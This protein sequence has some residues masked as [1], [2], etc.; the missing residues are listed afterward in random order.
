MKLWQLVSLG[1]LIPLLGQSGQQGLT[2]AEKNK[3]LSRKKWYGT[4]SFSVNGSGAGNGPNS[5]WS[6]NNSSTL[7]L[8]INEPIPGQWPPST[9]ADP[10]FVTQT[11][12][13]ITWMTM[14]T[15]AA[16]AALDRGETDPAKLP[17]HFY[18]IQRETKEQSEFRS[19]NQ[20]RKDSWTG[21][22][23]SFA[24]GPCMLAAD[25]KDGTYDVVFQVGPTDHGSAIKHEWSSD[26]GSGTDDAIP[27]QHMAWF[28]Q[29]FYSQLAKRKLSQDM[30]PD[31]SIGFN[32]TG[33]IKINGP[34]GIIE[35]TLVA[36]FRFSPTPPSN[37]KLIIEP[38]D[39]AEYQKWRPEPGD[40]EDESGSILEIK[41]RVEEP[42]V[43]RDRRAKPTRVTFRLG[44]VSRYPGVCMNWPAIPGSAPSSN[45]RGP[46][47]DLQFPATDDFYRSDYTV[48][49][50]KQVAIISGNSAGDGGGEIEVDCF[51]GAAIGEIVAEAELADGRII[52]GEVKGQPGSRKILIPDREEGVSDIAKVWRTRR[53]SGLK[54]E[55]DDEQIPAGDS[56]QGPGDG[57]SV[58]EEYRGFFQGGAWRDNC[59]PNRKDLFID[60]RIGARAQSGI[61]LFEQITSLAVHDKI[62]KD[63]HPLDL[64]INFRSR[65]DRHVVDQH[66]LLLKEVSGNVGNAT[67]MPG[68]AFPGPP[69]NTLSVR[70]VLG[71]PGDVIYQITP[72]VRY[73]RNAD[74]WMIS[75]ELGHG[76]GIYHH[77][78]RDPW[79]NDQWMGVKW[80]IRISAP[81]VS[82]G[83]PPEPI[84]ER[85]LSGPL[86]QVLAEAGLT[87]IPHDRLF[88][89][90]QNER[91]TII[92]KQ[93]GQ[94]SGDVDCVMRYCVAEAYERVGSPSVRIYKGSGEMPGGKL[95]TSPAGTLFN[96]PLNSPQS[97]YGGAD[98]NRGD[99]A[100]Q[101][102][103][104]DRWDKKYR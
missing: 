79:F 73:T 71:S 11:G 38:V 15:E 22:S 98:T 86:I 90:G 47:P 75:H 82:V 19:G 2:Q 34:M 14:P 58:W 41:W 74:A 12:R 32:I 99:C 83:Q 30:K 97:R 20:F 16:N 31:G 87:P 92:G 78:D 27:T 18:P 35:P 81:S 68:K 7:T 9:P 101:F 56:G 96:H 49:D 65:S 66:C 5:S 23:S 70:V 43:P 48:R 72:T 69:K 50:E 24:I 64:H 93:F 1:L 10:A 40:S 51:D 95:C 13:F 85:S 26:V 3:F 100:H 36:S 39:P 60:N 44:N 33:P 88:G 76:I 8:E 4:I 6:M 28:A 21:V 55:S 52:Q 77:G 62:N 29:E 67:A 63:E 103:I 57:L 94:H 104:S 80:C 25:L 46:K 17:N 53:A 89:P 84:F 102:V 59:F 61:K 37:A 91:I 54:D 42:G 45:V